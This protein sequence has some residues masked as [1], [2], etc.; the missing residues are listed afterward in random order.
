M[1]AARLEE[2]RHRES[3]DGSY[4]DDEAHKQQRRRWAA[5]DA[6]KDSGFS[7]TSSDCRSVVRRVIPDS[8]TDPTVAPS[9]APPPAPPPTT[10]EGPFQPATPTQAFPGFIQP[11]YIVGYGQGLMGTQLISAPLQ[12]CWPQPLGIAAAPPAPQFLFIQPQLA[13]TP[14]AGSCAAEPTAAGINGG[15]C[16]GKRAGAARPLRPPTI[17][18][19]IAP[20]PQRRIEDAA[21]TGG[22]QL[23][24]G[25]AVE[26]DD[27]SAAASSPLA[28]P[29]RRVARSSCEQTLSPALGVAP[30]SEQP[31][32][33]AV[34]HVPTAQ[35]SPIHAVPVGSPTPTQTAGVGAL[36]L[37]SPLRLPPSPSAAGDSYD[38]T[39]DVDDDDDA[40]DHE[41]PGR[42]AASPKARNGQSQRRHRHS[43]PNWRQHDLRFRNTVEI[44]NSSGLM[45]ATLRFKTLLQQSAATRRDIQQLRE[46]ARL[47]CEAARVGDPG[48]CLRV[49]EAMLRSGAYPG[50]SS[51]VQ[52]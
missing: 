33:T 27:V 21:P 14:S 38:H 25:P 3:N 35:A 10:Q 11:F 13:A 30:S 8:A 19:K 48:A 42:A 46:H 41:W 20:Y 32:A 37:P 34:A 17:Y 22:G 44:L 26:R 47:F 40:G 49:Q 45:E 9:P 23:P 16:S 1:E 51:L 31:N 28:V 7:D 15:D 12:S 18:P 36:L 4:R 24:S 52:T 5:A 50:L 2:R 39:D 43:A 6:E 29:S